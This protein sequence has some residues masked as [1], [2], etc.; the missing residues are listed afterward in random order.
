MHLFIKC[1]TTKHL[2]LPNPG[3]TTLLLQKI[4]LPK[5]DKNGIIRDGPSVV[6][7]AKT[8]D[9][10]SRY[11]TYKDLQYRKRGLTPP[12]KTLAPKSFCSQC[13]IM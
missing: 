7:G 6:I 2:L 13:S 8:K 11:E 10:K 3:K 1:Q 12:P 5:K 4:Y 9:G